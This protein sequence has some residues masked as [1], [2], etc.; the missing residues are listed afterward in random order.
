MKEKDKNDAATLAGLF[1]SAADEVLAAL[2]EI[3]DHGQHTMVEPLLKTISDWPHDAAIQR[4][5]RT[6]LTELKTE[7]AIPA[8]IDA[9]KK[10]SYAT[11]RAFVISVFWQAGIYPVEHIDVLVAQA[12]KGDYNVALEALTVI[13]NME[14]DWDYDELQGALLDIDEYLDKYPDAPHAAILKSLKEILIERQNQ[15]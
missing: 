1:S 6:I 4:K 5:A 2:N 10:E 14:A 13:E 11:L 7:A 15:A 9:L 3:H 8:L 12:I